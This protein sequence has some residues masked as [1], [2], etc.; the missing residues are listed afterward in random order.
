MSK[1]VL[2]KGG[3]R[4]TSL[5]E[6]LEQYKTKLSK[7]LDKVNAK[8]ADLSRPQPVGFRYGTAFK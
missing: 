8:L 4:Q 3:V 7:E 5:K 2:K 6:N 1:K